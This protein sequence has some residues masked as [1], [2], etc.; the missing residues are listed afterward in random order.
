MN[1]L[2]FSVGLTSLEAKRILNLKFASI[3]AKCS[4]FG[5]AQTF[6]FQQWVNF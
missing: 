4:H 6:K 2:S 1:I 3:G 5:T